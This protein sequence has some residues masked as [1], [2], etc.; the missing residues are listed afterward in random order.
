MY[1]QTPFCAYCVSL[2]QLAHRDPAKQASEAH[3]R[4]SSGR[5]SEGDSEVC[6]YNSNCGCRC[7][8]K[9]LISWNCGWDFLDRSPGRR[10][11]SSSVHYNGPTSPH[12]RGAATNRRKSFASQPHQLSHPGLF[13]FGCHGWETDPG[14]H[15]VGQTQRDKQSRRSIGWTGQAS[16]RSEPWWGTPSSSHLFSESTEFSWLWLDEEKQKVLVF[17]KP[18]SHAFLPAV[19]L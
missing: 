14:M 17:A 9:H 5:V 15:P 4:P 13:R 2:F 18:D 7:R 11:N 3:R 8:L 6:A 10:T 19:S 12:A 16:D 1:G